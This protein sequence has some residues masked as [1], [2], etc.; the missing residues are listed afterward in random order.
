M[1]TINSRDLRTR[2]PAVEYT[3]ITKIASNQIS[4]TPQAKSILNILLSWPVRA[5]EVLPGR[6]TTQTSHLTGLYL[7][8]R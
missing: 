6:L 7:K 2:I 3:S 1:N 5:A 4:E 8:A